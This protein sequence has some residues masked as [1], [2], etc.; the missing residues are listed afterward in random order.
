MLDKVACV[1]HAVEVRSAARCLLEPFLCPRKHL[2]LQ[3]EAVA[4]AL[5]PL[6]QRRRPESGR[7]ES[8]AQRFYRRL[9][10]LGGERVALALGNGLA[11]SE[12]GK[13]ACRLAA[14]A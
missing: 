1:A 12:L 11:L 5:E 13:L 10:E 2:L 6:L 8:R 7:F 9:L 4:R 14:V 3:S